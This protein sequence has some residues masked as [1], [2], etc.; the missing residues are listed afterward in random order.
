MPKKL[1][2]LQSRSIEQSIIERRL[3]RVKQLAIRAGSLVMFG[4]KT[5]KHSVERVE[6]DGML[7]LAGWPKPLSALQVWGVE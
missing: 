2:V 1:T 5:R 6:P 3:A 7:I 4:Q